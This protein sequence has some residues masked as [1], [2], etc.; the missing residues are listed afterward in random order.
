MKKQLDRGILIAFEGI[1]G[2]GKSTIAQSIF[3]YLQEKGVEVILTAQPSDTEL[4]NNV[5]TIIN[6]P[7]STTISPMFELFLFLA[8]RAENV[9]KIIKPALEQGKIVL[10]DRYSASSLAYQGY[11]RGIDINMIKN[12]N[13][14][15]TENTAPDLTIYLRIDPE[16]AHKRLE[17]RGKLTS[18]EQ[19]NS[20]MQRVSKGFDTIFLGDQNVKTLDA[21]KSLEELKS[22]ALSFVLFIYACR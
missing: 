15:A 9:N 3:E 1:D 22:E 4:G 17:Q 19:D 10:V 18:F 11:G 14:L 20:F 13:K 8:D 12:F 21:S 2:A 7:P 16:L 6:T 5:R